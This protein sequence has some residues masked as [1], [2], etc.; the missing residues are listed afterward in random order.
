MTKKQ[1]LK[2]IRP[3]LGKLKYKD[4]QKLLRQLHR[5][6][7]EDFRQRMGRISARLS[8]ALEVGNSPYPKL[9]RGGPLRVEPLDVTL[10]LMTFDVDKLKLWK[11]LPK[12]RKHR[13]GR[14]S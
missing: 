9:R 3:I 6:E 4:V 13:K 5:Q 12:K 14:K 10:K 11:E 8:K 2:E 1:L 7:L